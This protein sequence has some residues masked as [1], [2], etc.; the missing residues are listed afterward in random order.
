MVSKLQ[1]MFNF[2]TTSTAQIDQISKDENNVDE[3]KM[4]KGIKSKS[5]VNSILLVYVSMSFVPYQMQSVWVHQQGVP[6]ICV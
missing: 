4:M 1:N 5:T 2:P 3:R 6:S